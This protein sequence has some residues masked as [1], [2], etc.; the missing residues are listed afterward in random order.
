MTDLTDDDDDVDDD[1]DEPPWSGVFG[2]DGRFADDDRDGLSDGSG[3][4]WEE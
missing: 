3:E 1:R 2:C 4:M